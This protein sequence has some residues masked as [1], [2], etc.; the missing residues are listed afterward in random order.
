[1]LTHNYKTMSNPSITLSLPDD[2]NN[3][4]RVLVQAG[5]TTGQVKLVEEE[6]RIIIRDDK[7]FFIG[8][9]PKSV[10]DVDKS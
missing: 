7:D 10:F 1:M 5:V 9:V 2:L 4:E 3:I 8:S 6:A